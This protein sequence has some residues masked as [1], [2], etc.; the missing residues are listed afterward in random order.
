MFG[1]NYEIIFKPK[2]KFSD[3]KNLDVLKI[4]DVI[5]FEG[6]RIKKCEPSYRYTHP[7]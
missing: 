1:L 6:R 5:D 3:S 4:Y 2:S 7:G